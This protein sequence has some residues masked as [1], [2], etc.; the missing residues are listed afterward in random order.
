MVGE[1]REQETTEGVDAE[2]GERH[3][4][5]LPTMTGE[6]EADDLEVRCLFPGVFSQVSFPRCLFPGPPWKRH[7]GKD[8]G[9]KTPL[10]R[11]TPGMMDDDG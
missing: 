8:T 11:K 4:C 3:G 1:T 7:R 10:P 9:E 2:G 5:R 6:I